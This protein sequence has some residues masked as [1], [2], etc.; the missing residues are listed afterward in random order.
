MPPGIVRR[1]PLVRSGEVIFTRQ[2]KTP[3]ANRSLAVSD[4]AASERPAAQP[5]LT[6]TGTGIL[7]ER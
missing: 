6:G 3:C 1:R 7:V 5:R 2:K 4:S